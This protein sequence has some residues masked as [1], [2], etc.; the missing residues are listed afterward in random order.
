MWGHKT[1]RKWYVIL[2]LFIC[3]LLL[4]L[5]PAVIAMEKA[6]CTKFTMDAVQPDNIISSAIFGHIAFKR[7]TGSNEERHLAYLRPLDQDLVQTLPVDTVDDHNIALRT[8]AT[9][10]PADNMHFDLFTASTRSLSVR[11]RSGVTAYD[12]QACIVHR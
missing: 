9:F 6:N 7:I 3:V 12:L 10:P 1:V 4:M 8:F 5:C 2:E 11:N